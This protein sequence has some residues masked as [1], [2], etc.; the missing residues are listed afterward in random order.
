MTFVPPQ[1]P[2]QSFT[3]PLQ[4]PPLRRDGG[5]PHTHIDR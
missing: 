5:P 1:S 4:Q 3:S 2:A